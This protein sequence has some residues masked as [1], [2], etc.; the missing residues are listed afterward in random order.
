MPVPA[1]EFMGLAAAVQWLWN[2]E[3]C[4]SFL[5]CDHKHTHKLFHCPA[6]L[7][8][9]IFSAQNEDWDLFVASG[10]ASFQLFGL[11]FTVPETNFHQSHISCKSHQLHFLNWSNSQGFFSYLS[12]L[13][14]KHIS[15][16]V[17]SHKFHLHPAMNFFFF[18]L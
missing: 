15:F 7:I 8:T 13:G 5:L 18:S 2:K 3:D 14:Y 17:S 10:K 9:N 12:N 16:Q 6:A 11:F 1:L 4:M